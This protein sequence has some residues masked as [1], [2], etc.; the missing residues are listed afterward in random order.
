MKGKDPRPELKVEV[1]RQEWELTLEGEP[2]LCCVLTR[3]ECTGTWKGLDAIG[4]YYSRV[5]EV[6]RNRW[7]KELYVH[8]CLDLADRRAAGRPFRKWQAELVT[9]VTLQEG[10]L[11]S[12]WQEGRETRGYDRPLMLRRGDTW[13]LA[14]G[15]PRTLASFFPKER[16]WKR[17]VLAQVTEQIQERLE[18]GE[19]LLDRDCVGRLRREFDAENYYLTPEGVQLFFPMDTLAPGGEGI[20]V[21]TVKLPGTGG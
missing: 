20:P 9:Q 11:F 6:W 15:A 21:F 18:G 7:E 14:E 17:K 13:S 2:V 12:L 4:R 19:S 1:K 8:A 5:L 10:G 16:R 3:P